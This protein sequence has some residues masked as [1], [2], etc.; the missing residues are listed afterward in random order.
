MG[1][2]DR[3]CAETAAAAPVARNVLR[4]TTAFYR[5]LAVI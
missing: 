5:L 3:L 4:F 2:P 1:V